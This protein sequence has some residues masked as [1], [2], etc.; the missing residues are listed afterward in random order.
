MLDSPAVVVAN[1]GLFGLEGEIGTEDEKTTKVEPDT[2]TIAGGQVAVQVLKPEI[3]ARHIGRGIHQPDIAGISK[4]RAVDLDGA[5]PDGNDREPVFRIQLQLDI[6]RLVHEK[7]GCIVI[8]QGIEAARAQHPGP[9]SPD[10]VGAT[11]K[12]LLDIGQGS[13][14]I[15]GNAH[16]AV[17]PEGPAGP[18]ILDILADIE[19]HP[20]IFGKLQ[21]ISRPV[22]GVQRIDPV[23]QEAAF[24]QAQPYDTVGAGIL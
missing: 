3:G 12:V 23:H 22:Q 4:E 18:V 16:A 19:I 11:H 5:G 14:F 9:P 2:E 21:P 7:Q 20:D 6:A 17:K 10:A 24:F 1:I 15:V 13:G 8:L